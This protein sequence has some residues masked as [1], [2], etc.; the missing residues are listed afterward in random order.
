MR[1][2]RDLPLALGQPGALDPGAQTLA[3]VEGCRVGHHLPLEVLVSE[4]IT[5]LNL[6]RQQRER[7]LMGWP[8]WQR[9]LV[10]LIWSCG[11]G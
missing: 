9:W 10:G 7:R 4:S 11:L 8:Q 5:H 3:P 2:P 6:H 1:R